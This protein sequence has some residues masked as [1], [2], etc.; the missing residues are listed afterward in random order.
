[1]HETWLSNY[2]R[3]LEENVMSKKKYHVAVV[4]ATGAVG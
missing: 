4:G 1:M 2:L 3:A